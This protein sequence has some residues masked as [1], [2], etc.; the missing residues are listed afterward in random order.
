MAPTAPPTT[1]KRKPLRLKAT[2]RLA[3]PLAPRKVHRP[4]T[5]AVTDAFLNTKSDKRLIRHSTFLG[6]IGKPRAT[7]TQ[8]KNLKRREKK[9]TADAA[10]REMDGL[11]DA[12]PS[13]TAEEVSAGAAERDGRVRL[14][15]L[16]SK[17]GAL[18]KKER[19][20]RGEMERFGVVSAQLAAVREAVAA[21][22][23]EEEDDDAEDA[24]MKGAPF[25]E[26]GRQQPSVAAN[27]FAALRGFI[28][29]TMEQNPAFQQRVGGGAK[30]T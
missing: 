26:V 16:R 7:P 30:A 2:E 28:S 4:D 14:K 9:K 29:A 1:T 21:P 17:P 12:L 3:N 13:L 18:R 24:E 6:R 20:V 23:K 25:A 11:A 22:A 27:R 8:R 19:V 15:S 10:L 5:T